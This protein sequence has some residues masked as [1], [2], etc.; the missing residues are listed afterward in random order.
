M[1]FARITNGL[2]V[3]AT[4]EAY[5]EAWA[6]A[7]QVPVRPYPTAEWN[8]SVWVG[9]PPAQADP[10]VITRKLDMINRMTDGEAAAVDDALTNAPAKMKLQWSGAPNLIHSDAPEYPELRAFISGVLSDVVYPDDAAQAAARL[11]IIL[12]ASEVDQ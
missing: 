6:P 5:P 12:A 10:V 7:D 8:G 9:D 3:Q 4:S 1:E 2:Y 11:D